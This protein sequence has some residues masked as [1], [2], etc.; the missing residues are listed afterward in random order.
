MYGFISEIICVMNSGRAVLTRP[1]FEV[2]PYRRP[3]NPS[4]MTE[5]CSPKIHY[6]EDLTIFG[7]RAYKEVIKVKPGHKGEAFI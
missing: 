3:L 7:H 5:M 2:V 6:V 4:C 1:Y